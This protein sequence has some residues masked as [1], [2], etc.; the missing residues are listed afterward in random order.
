MERTLGFVIPQWK[1]RRGCVNLF[2]IFRSKNL[3]QACNLP[4]HVQI[5]SLGAIPLYSNK[6][7]KVLLLMYW[8]NEFYFRPQVS[9]W[10]FF[11]RVIIWHLY[12]NSCRRRNLFS[13]SILIESFTMMRGVI[14]TVAVCLILALFCESKRFRDRPRF[15]GRGGKGQGKRMFWDESCIP[16]CEE[17]QIGFPLIMS[18]DGTSRCPEEFESKR[19]VKDAM[20]RKWEICGAEVC[21]L[22]LFNSWL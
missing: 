14:A 17:G 1:M 20:L 2:D 16:T 22:I 9:S 19:A 3:Y 11:V 10:T 18:D 15:G 5:S 13:T 7:L 21:R 8:M 12:V 6:K 4:V